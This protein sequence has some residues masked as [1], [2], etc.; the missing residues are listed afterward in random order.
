MKYPIKT[1]LEQVKIIIQEKKKNVSFNVSELAAE[2]EM[3]KA[4][5]NRKVKKHMGS[6][7]SKLIVYSRMELAIQLLG[8]S[9]FSIEKIA[10][11]CGFSSRSS[12]SRRFKQEFNIPP[13]LFRKQLLSNDL[14]RRKW[15]SPLD[16]S[17]FIHIINLS[18][19]HLWLNQL[20]IIIL[21]DVN[22]KITIK[23]VSKLLFM[24][25]STLNNK[26]NNLF[27][28]STKRLLLDVKLY[29]VAQVLIMQDKTIKDV[30]LAFDFY[31]SVHLSKSFMHIYNKSIRSFVAQKLRK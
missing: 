28:I 26:V 9:S 15:K 20:L 11:E 1:L 25:I 7:L 23:K 24:D 12:F 4:Q 3:S 30:V 6:S 27:G 19:R 10:C 29:F 2:L 13:F 21:A 17:D 14:E 18:R 8:S 31:D 5:L 16:E 22:K